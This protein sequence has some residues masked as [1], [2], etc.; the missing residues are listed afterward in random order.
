MSPIITIG[1]GTFIKFGSFSARAVEQKN[2]TLD[3]GSFEAKIKHK[4][5]VEFAL[6]QQVLAQKF[7]VRLIVG[8]V[9]ILQLKRVSRRFGTVLV[10]T[11]VVGVQ[12]RFQLNLLH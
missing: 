2:L 5:F 10:D 9:E 1:S 7:V 11:I 4:I 12:N 6:E 3:L 8:S